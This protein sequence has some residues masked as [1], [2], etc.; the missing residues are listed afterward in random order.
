MLE[1]TIRVV[2]TAAFF[3]SALR[4]ATPLMLAAVGGTFSERSGVLNLGLEGMMLIGA[5]C[6]F[7]G[8]Y[9]SGSPW[10]GLVFAVLGSMVFGLIHAFCCVSLGLNQ[11]VVAV[12][13]NI[14][15]LGLSGSLLRTMFGATTSQLSCKGFTPIEIPLL[16]NIPFV[17]EVFFSQNILFYLVA[18]LIPAM[19]FIF[20]KTTWG[21]KL[22]SVGE[23]PKAAETMGVN[24]LKVRYTCILLS[25]A[26]AGIAGASLSISGL[27]TFVDNLTAGRGFIAFAAIIFGKYHPV[28]AALGALFFGIA[29][30][31]QLNMQAMGMNIP[32]QIPLMM[33]YVLT[34]I[35]LFIVGAGTAP[36]SSGVPYV[37]GN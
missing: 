34:I 14:L 9:F 10:I 25:A 19:W 4:L 2:F 30:C 37:P 20:F 13:I 17:G 26:F 5:F 36:K 6:G 15:G 11:V 23:Y 31:L 16:S 12:A 1:Q 18:L 8:S 24:V 28:G 33:P 7:A 32:Y 35:L 22:R 29:D 3:A 27:N 21:L